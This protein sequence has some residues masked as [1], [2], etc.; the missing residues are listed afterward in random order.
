MPIDPATALRLADAANP[1]TAVALAINAAILARAGEMLRRAV[2]AEDAQAS[3]T[4]ADVNRARTEVNV[5]LQERAALRGRV[6]TTSARV[7][8]LLLLRPT[9][10]LQPVD[11]LI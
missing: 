10:H 2:A 9:V 3:K 6:A 11:P 7:A 1:T 8:R 4:T 5:R